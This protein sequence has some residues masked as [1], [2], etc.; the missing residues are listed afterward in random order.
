MARVKVS[1]C[2]IAKDEERM[3]PGCLESVRGVA[4]EIVLV[5]TGSTDRTRELARAAGARVLERPW[6]DDFAAP[7]NL[8]AAHAT[9]DWILPLDADERLAPAAGAALRRALRG[10]AFDVG[11]VRCHNADAPDAPA[12]EVLS[13]ARRAGPPALLPRVVRRAPGLRWAGRIHESVLDWAAA[14]GGRI[15]PLDLDVVHLGYAKEIWD[16]RGKRARNLALLR[17]R[18]EEEPDSVIAL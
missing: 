7:R 9:G 2:L 14:R 6:D 3:L 13:G 15:V 18:A 10:A 1:L 16:G 8:A 17:R 11:L 12:A 5:D 4:D